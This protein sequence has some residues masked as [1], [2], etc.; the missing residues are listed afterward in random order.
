M[1]DISRYLN[2]IK[3]AVKGEEVRGSI[4]DAIDAINKEV[5]G[6]TSGVNSAIKGIDEKKAAMDTFMTTTRNNYNLFQTSIADR[7]S[8]LVEAGEMN[9][10]A[11]NFKYMTHD[12]WLVW[13]NLH[14]G[15]GQFVAEDY[16]VVAIIPNYYWRYSDTIVSATNHDY[17]CTGNIVTCKTDLIIKGKTDDITNAISVYMSA[18]A[19][20]SGDSVDRDPNPITEVALNEFGYYEIPAGNYWVM[21]LNNSA[22]ELNDEDIDDSVIIS[23]KAI[24]EIIINIENESGTYLSTAIISATG[25]SK[26]AN[27][28]SATYKFG[29]G[30]SH[31]LIP[32]DNVVN[33]YVKVASSSAANSNIALLTDDPGNNYSEGA[34]IDYVVRD[35]NI[36]AGY[37]WTGVKYLQ[38]FTQAKYAWINT[39]YAG[40]SVIFDSILLTMA[41]G[42]QIELIKNNAIDIRVLGEFTLKT[43]VSDLEDKNYTFNIENKAVR[44]YRNE[45]DYTNDPN[46]NYSILS[47]TSYGY[48]FAVNTNTFSYKTNRPESFILTWDAVQDAVNYIIKIGERTYTTTDTSFS[49]SN[50]IPGEKYKYEVAALSG[51]YN[52]TIIKTGYINTEGQIRMINVSNVSNVRDFG[53]WQ[54]SFG[55]R[56]KYGKIFRGAAFDDTGKSVLTNEGAAEIMANGITVEVD[57][58]GDSGI[59]YDT[60]YLKERIHTPVQSYTTGLQS[61]STMFAALRAIMSA[62]VSGKGVYIHCRQ[63]ADR[64]GTVS[65]VLESLL[66]VSIIDTTTDYE[67]TSF[68]TYQDIAGS[69]IITPRNGSSFTEMLTYLNDFSGNNMTEKIENYYI[70]IGGTKEE[71]NAFRAA[72]L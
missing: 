2:Q 70:S 37:D 4:H 71:I 13:S 72:M 49:V 65:F 45:I 15:T 50:M 68:S 47:A 7:I 3:A 52:K 26:N 48:Y 18:G 9:F 24:W 36:V 53:G 55:K 6:N 44:R 57:L 16:P 56:I 33:L 63:G 41:N 38:Y 11:M 23:T 67:L 31:I 5:M 34:T 58:R 25:A 27:A 61:G 20:T 32:L 22:L 51:D 19:F 62:V 29:T 66:G 46:C 64:A 28:S 40:N 12:D 14:F 21:N 39:A 59:D 60:I 54:T 35:N 8:E 43:R 17:Y 69:A 1:A 30:Y 42:Q 10:S